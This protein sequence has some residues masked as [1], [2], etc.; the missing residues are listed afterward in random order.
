M[1][2]PADVNQ[3]GVGY[4]RYPADM[5]ECERGDRLLSADMAER[6]CGA[7]GYLST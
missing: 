3:R 6:R 5:D 2:L 1:R 4:M 7:M